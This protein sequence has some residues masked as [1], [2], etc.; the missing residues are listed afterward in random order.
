MNTLKTEIDYLKQQPLWVAFPDMEPINL[1]DTQ[2]LYDYV[3]TVWADFW[4]PLTPEQRND[5][6]KHW[7]ASPEWVEALSFWSER[8]GDEA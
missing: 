3:N 1:T 6:L 7:E 4:M 2:G 8:D 5:Y